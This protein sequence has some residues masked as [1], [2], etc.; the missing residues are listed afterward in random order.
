MPIGERMKSARW[1]KKSWA[2]A[3]SKLNIPGEEIKFW[4]LVEKKIKS[5]YPGDHWRQYQEWDNI[6]VHLSNEAMNR[7]LKKLRGPT[8]VNT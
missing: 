2:N 5:K 7:R 8:D 4:D 3:I 6:L 1:D